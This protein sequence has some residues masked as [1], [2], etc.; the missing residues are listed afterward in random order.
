M[1]DRTITVTDRYIEKHGEALSLL[2]EIEERLMEMPAPFTE[3]FTPNWG[4][5]GDLDLLINRLRTAR[6]EMPRA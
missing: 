2:A 1:Q 6:D 4:H 3:G 5:V